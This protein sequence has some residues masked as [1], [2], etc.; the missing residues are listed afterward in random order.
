MSR[1]R[2][3]LADDH[4]LVAEAFRK[5]VEP[6]YEV[7]G[8]VADGRALIAAARSL[9][10]D[11]IVVDLAMPLL[12]GLEATA[13][14][15]QLSPKSK[16]I[17]VTMEEDSSVA[18]DA[19]RKGASGYLLKTAAASELLK[20][21]QDVLKS[22]SY[23][24]PQIAQGMMDSWVRDPRQGQGKHLTQRQREVVQLLAE[25]RTMKQVAAILSITPRTVAFH[26]YK[27]MEEFGLKSNAELFQFAVREHMITAR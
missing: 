4:T 6:H 26:K 13:Q 27:I 8:I 12:N 23:V 11:V 15:R 7:V 10:P 5:L 20:A 3:L 14:L 21:I 9:K 25:G 19:I 16:I 24:T 22:K 17:I 1:A 2:V 18:A